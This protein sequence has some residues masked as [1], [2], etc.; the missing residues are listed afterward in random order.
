M[1]NLSFGQAN[2]YEDTYS[3][4]DQISDATQVSSAQRGM[5]IQDNSDIQSEVG[6]RNLNPPKNFVIKFQ[7]HISRQ[8]SNQDGDGII[9]EE[10]K[11]GNE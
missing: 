5:L 2:E 6:D 10:I 11:E 7:S 4:K 1:T 9:E 3:P 8:G